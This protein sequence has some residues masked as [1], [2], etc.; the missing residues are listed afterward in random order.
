LW[1]VSVDGGQPVQLTD[2][3]SLSPAVSPDG[4]RIAYAF[5]DGQHNKNIGIISIRGGPL[6]Q[7]LPLSSTVLVD[8]GLGL[9]WT[10]DGKSIVYVD[11]L[12]GVSNIWIQ[13][14]DGS[15]PKQITNFKSEEIF[16]YDFSPNGEIAVTRGNLTRDVVMI[17]DFR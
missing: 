10:S 11:N 13:P 6:L 4:E 5:L 8:V 12:G 16:S 14:L 2:H 7:T 1:K 3:P 9:R 17:R 15:P